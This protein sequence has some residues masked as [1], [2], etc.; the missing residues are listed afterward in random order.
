MLLCQSSENGDEF[1]AAVLRYQNH[2]RIK[3]ILQN[4]NFSFYFK[5]V[6]F[7]NIEKEKESLNTNKIFHSCDIPTKILK[8]NVDFFFPFTFGYVDKSISSSTF[9][10]I[11]KLRDIIPVHEKYS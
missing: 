6:S 7:T 10:L 8:Q 9:P 4:C 2:P 5:T 11:L 3:T 1:L